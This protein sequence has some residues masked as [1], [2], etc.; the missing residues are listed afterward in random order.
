MTGLN[1]GIPGHTA[2]YQSEGETPR[3]HEPVRVDLADIV[4]VRTKADAAIRR[5]RKMVQLDA[6]DVM[7][8]IDAHL[9]LAQAYEQLDEEA[10][11]HFFDLCDCETP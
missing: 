11:V 6:T 5:G 8:L 3:T 2:V 9:R 10:A 7:R 4:A 1:V